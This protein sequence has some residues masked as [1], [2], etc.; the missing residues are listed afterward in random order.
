MAVMGSMGEALLTTTPVP[1]LS[2]Q[3]ALL[4]ELQSAESSCQ[5]RTQDSCKDDCDWNEQ[6][7]LCEISA[8][9]AISMLGGGSSSFGT[10]TRMAP[11]VEKSQLAALSDSLSS[12]LTKDV[13]K[14]QLSE[15][16]AACESLEQSVSCVDECDWDED[17]GRCDVHPLVVLRVIA[18]SSSS[19]PMEQDM[20]NRAYVVAASQLNLSA[21]HAECSIRSLPNLS[22][23]SHAPIPAPCL[24][25][26][27]DAL[28]IWFAGVQFVPN[29]KYKAVCKIDH[30]EKTTSTFGPFS[31]QLSKSAGEGQFINIAVT[32]N[33]PSTDH[34]IT[35]PMA[36]MIASTSAPV[37]QVGSSGRSSTFMS[38]PIVPT[39]LPPKHVNET[40]KNQT[41]L[42]QHAEASTTVMGNTTA[43]VD[44]GMFESFNVYPLLGVA[45]I[46]LC[47]MWY[48]HTVVSRRPAARMGVMRGFDDEFVS[49]SGPE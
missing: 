28:L 21:V 17:R 33:A 46:V 27:H 22:R 47:G 14:A 5:K 49:L 26:E 36:S 7:K 35:S 32:T 29:G 39:A 18:R 2:D 45:A 6:N 9:F 48:R 20:H 4:K 15:I 13:S 25:K 12:L 38:T 30:E 43:T 41:L 24:D 42:P 1:T 19:A 31:V 11:E 16:A 8:I 34:A 23:F 40:V 37:V 10:T 3:H 44:T